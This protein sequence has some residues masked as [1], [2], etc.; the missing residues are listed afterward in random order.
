MAPVN[1]QK[2]ENML[3]CIVAGKW[4]L[5]VSYNSQT[6]WSAGVAS[7]ITEVDIHI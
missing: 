3:T 6:Q 7:T 2:I 4:E 1:I 5:C